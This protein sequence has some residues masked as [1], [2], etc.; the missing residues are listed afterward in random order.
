[1]AGFEKERPQIQE[2]LLQQ[3]KFKSWEAWMNQLR[4]RSQIDKKQDFTP[5]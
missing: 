4:N 3:K 1:M 2:R 5:I